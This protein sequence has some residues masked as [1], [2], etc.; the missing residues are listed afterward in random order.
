VR[1]AL[2]IVVFHIFQRG[3][4]GLR[5]DV[6]TLCARIVDGAVSFDGEDVGLAILFGADIG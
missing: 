4:S 1:L 3:E 6:V 5:E 2:F